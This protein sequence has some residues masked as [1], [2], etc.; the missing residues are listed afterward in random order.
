MNKFINE[1]LIEDFLDKT[2]EYI[3]NKVYDS[4]V[5]VTIGNFRFWL[6]DNQPEKLSEY[7]YRI[8]DGENPREVITDISMY[9]DRDN[10]ELYEMMQIIFERFK[11]KCINDKRMDGLEIG[12][13]YTVV[14][15]Y[16]E[17]DTE[18]YELEFNQSGE[19]CTVYD[20]TRF[21]K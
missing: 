10:Q 20:K 5:L 6:E 12:S 2:H 4:M 15:N 17:D 16:I 21:K 9:F 3:L 7:L 11:V 18:Y 19:P 1:S 8:S 14:D 13:T